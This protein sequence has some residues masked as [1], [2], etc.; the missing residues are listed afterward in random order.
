MDTAFKGQTATQWPQRIDVY[1]RQIIQRYVGKPVYI[2]NDVNLLSWAERKAAHLEDVQNMLYIV[3]RSGIGMA[4]WTDGSLMQGEMGNSGRIGHMTVDK[5]GL[6]CKCGSRGC[7]GLY[8]SEKA[9]MRTVSYTHLIRAVHLV[10]NISNHGKTFIGPALKQFFVY[11]QRTDNCA[12]QLHIFLEQLQAD[13]YKRQA[14]ADAGFIS[15]R[16]RYM[17]GLFS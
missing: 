3:I 10:G 6:E 2:C 1:K 13:V 11:L 5:N 12:E 8:T 4:I 7:L 14:P 17:S 15:S 9:M 16:S